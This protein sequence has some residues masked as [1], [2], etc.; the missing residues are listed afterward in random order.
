MAMSDLKQTHPDQAGA[1]SPR[2]RRGSGPGA[3]LPRFPADL[4]LAAMVLMSG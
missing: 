1:P 2:I 3:D 4:V